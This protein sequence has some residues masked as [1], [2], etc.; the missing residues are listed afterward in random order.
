[1]AAASSIL[2]LAKLFLLERGIVLKILQWFYPVE[3]PWGSSLKRDYNFFALSILIGMLALTEIWFR[4]ERPLERHL[5]SALLGA[6]AVAGAYAGSRR[7]WLVAPL[8][9]GAQFAF[10]WWRGARH[11]RAGG[12]FRPPAFQVRVSF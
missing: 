7:F 12:I 5:L 9:L 1:M 8:V 2:G 3:Y 11:R 4:S 6:M 10:V